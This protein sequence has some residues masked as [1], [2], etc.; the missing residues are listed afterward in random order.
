[1]MMTMSLVEAWSPQ[2][3]SYSQ[4]IIYFAKASFSWFLSPVIEKEVIR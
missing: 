3:S 1:M 2:T 4:Q